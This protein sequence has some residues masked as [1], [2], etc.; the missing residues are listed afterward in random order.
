[1]QIIHRLLVEE[2]IFSTVLTDNLVV[3]NAK[4]I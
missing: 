4:Y 1:M 2:K 3:E